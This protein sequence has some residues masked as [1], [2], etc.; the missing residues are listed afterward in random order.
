MFAPGAL[1][2]TGALLMRGKDPV[3]P[4]SH[5]FR[6]VSLMLVDK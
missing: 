4:D 6:T 3:L 1:A 5:W 2:S